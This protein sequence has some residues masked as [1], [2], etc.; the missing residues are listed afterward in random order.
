MEREEEGDLK[1]VALSLG[2]GKALSPTIKAW[3]GV[4]VEG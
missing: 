4:S 1:V 3:V 2:S